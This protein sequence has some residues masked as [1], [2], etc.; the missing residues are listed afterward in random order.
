MRQRAYRAALLAALA[1][2]LFACAHN[3]IMAPVTRAFGV[4][5]ESELARCRVALRG[6]QARIETSRVRVMPVLFVA[7]GDGA[8]HGAYRVWRSDLARGLAAEVGARTKAHLE[9]SPDG[10]QAPLPE[11][12]YHN[13][14]RYLWDR[15]ALYSQWVK[16]RP[17]GTDYVLVAEVF[18]GEGKREAALQL[19]VLDAQ[20]Q[21]A[22]CRLAR[23]NG[24]ASDED[25]RATQL[26][27]QMLFDTLKMDADRVFPPYGWG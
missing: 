27:V 23:F 10:P 17:P 24:N 9:V 18:S 22:L 1:A 21:V 26:L 14:L 19:Y 3:E 12:M 7:N 2:G 4:P 8:W 11:H 6:L 5:P 20:G 13:Q 25:L 16:S 15:A